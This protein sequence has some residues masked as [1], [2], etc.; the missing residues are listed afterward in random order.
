MLSHNWGFQMLSGTEN[1]LKFVIENTDRNFNQHG[2][3]AF[4]QKHVLCLCWLKTLYYKYTILHVWF[5]YDVLH[6]TEIDRSNWK[7]SISFTVSYGLD[8]WNM[9]KK[10]MLVCL[11]TQILQET[12]QIYPDR[13]HRLKQIITSRSILYIGFN[14]VFYFPVRTQI[15]CSLWK[16]MY[17]TP[18][19]GERR[20][21]MK[22]HFNE[23]WRMILL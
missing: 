15:T 21:I 12:I 23:I 8:N 9:Q 22:L 5:W 13:M 10:L 19:K 3:Y 20:A 1:V 4:S 18:K 14:A 17:S 16:K 7:F 11:S 2:K 6:M